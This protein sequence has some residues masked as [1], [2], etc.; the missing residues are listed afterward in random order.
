VSVES[1]AQQCR[2]PRAVGSKQTEDDSARHTETHAVDGADRGFP[3][4][5]VH[6]YEVFN[7]QANSLI[8]EIQSGRR[9]TWHTAG[10]NRQ[11]EQRP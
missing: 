10:R 11:S 8:Y 1:Y 5:G 4:E 2:L 3:R 6:F 7:F 9:G